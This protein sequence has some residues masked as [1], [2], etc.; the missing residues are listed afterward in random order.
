MFPFM[1]ILENKSQPIATVNKSVVSLSYEWSRERPQ[2]GKEKYSG[3]M[4]IF[5]IMNVVE[6]IQVYKYVKSHNTLH[7][8]SLNHSM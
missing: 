2:M 3:L 4:E 7:L 5:H 6:V 8:K 1:L